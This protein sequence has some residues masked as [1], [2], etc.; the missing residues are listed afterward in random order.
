[1]G[2]KDGGCVMIKARKYKDTDMDKM[3]MGGPVRGPAV[4]PTMTDFHVESISPH[5]EAAPRGKTKS[6]ITKKPAGV[7]YLKAKQ[8]EAFQ[9]T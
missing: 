9:M 6:P 8:G 2:C 7:A 5:S 3:A 4:P 1:M